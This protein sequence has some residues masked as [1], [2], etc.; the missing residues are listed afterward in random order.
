MA[1]PVALQTMGSATGLVGRRSCFHGNLAFVSVRSPMLFYDKDSQ[2]LFT[3]AKV[4]LG[5]H[6]SM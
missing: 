5:I 2:L 6:W 1:K 4:G 3:A